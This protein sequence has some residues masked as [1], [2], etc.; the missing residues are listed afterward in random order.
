MTGNQ[1]IRTLTSYMWFGL[2]ETTGTKS[3]FLDGERFKSM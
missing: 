1:K 2:G 3:L